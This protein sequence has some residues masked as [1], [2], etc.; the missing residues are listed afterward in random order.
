MMDSSDRDI[1]SLAK[2]PFCSTMPENKA[3]VIC[4]LNAA[5]NFEVTKMF[6]YTAHITK[7]LWGRRLHT[8][9]HNSIMYSAIHDIRHL[10]SFII[11]LIICSAVLYTNSHIAHDSY[12]QISNVRGVPGVA[13]SNKK[14]GTIVL[15]RSSDGSMLPTEMKEEVLIIFYQRSQWHV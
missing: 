11:I 9:V 5:S 6:S 10:Y 8:L 14:I 3:H 7:C 2:Y 1:L 13:R 12:L 4:F 15:I